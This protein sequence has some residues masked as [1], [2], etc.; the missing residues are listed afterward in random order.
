[1]VMVGKK[2]RRM[3]TDF[4]KKSSGWSDCFSASQGTMGKSE[5]VENRDIVLINE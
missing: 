4:R 1:M 2:E 5:N 3:A